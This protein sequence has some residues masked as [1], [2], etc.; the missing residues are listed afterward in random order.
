MWRASLIRRRRETLGTVWAPGRS[1]RYG[2]ATLAETIGWDGKLTDW[3][4]NITADCPRKHYIRL[5]A[6]Q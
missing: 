4:Y 3:L 1:G 5:R 6:S 2:V